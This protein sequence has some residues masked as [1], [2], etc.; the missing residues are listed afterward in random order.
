MLLKEIVDEP[1]NS[2]DIV[3]NKTAANVDKLP[4][5]KLQFKGQGYFSDV[6]DI[7]DN[8]HEIV[9]HSSQLTGAKATEKYQKQDKEDYDEGFRYYAEA[10]LAD[11]TAVSNPYFPRIRVYVADKNE[12]QYVIET[13]IDPSSI[14]HWLDGDVSDPEFQHQ[15]NM[16][17]VLGQ[18]MFS[19]W[20]EITAWCDDDTQSTEILDKIIALIDYGCNGGGIQTTDK[21]LIQALSLIRDLKAS[22][23]RLAVDI[24]EGNVMFRRSKFGLQLVITDPLTFF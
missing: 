5:H 11:N 16:I 4:Q 9:K 10:I 7:D 21:K 17:N 23:R 20:G 12:H 19:N 18:Q 8:P 3:R 24:H 6:Y 22:N 13:L 1:Y 2:N 14:F 15:R